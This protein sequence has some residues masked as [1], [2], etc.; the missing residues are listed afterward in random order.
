MAQVP[1]SAGLVLVDGLVHLDQE[2]AMFAAMLAG[3]SRPQKSR[4]LSSSTIGTRIILL[5]RFTTFAESFPW[6]GPW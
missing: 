3:W 6:A 5:R 1:G 4:L 2:S